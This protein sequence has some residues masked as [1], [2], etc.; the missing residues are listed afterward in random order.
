MKASGPSKT[1]LGGTIKVTTVWPDSLRAYSLRAYILRA[2]SLVAQIA[3]FTFD[4]PN[5]GGLFGYILGAYSLRAQITE[6]GSHR[7]NTGLQWSV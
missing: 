6:F 3:E 2:D 5:T 1:G 7:P 4:R